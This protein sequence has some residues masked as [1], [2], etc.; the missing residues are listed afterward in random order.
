MSGSPS[1]ST[2]ESFGPRRGG[3]PRGGVPDLGV[4][5]AYSDHMEDHEPI[6][7]AHKSGPKADIAVVVPERVLADTPV[8]ADSRERSY[9]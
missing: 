7:L 3:R 6:D 5:Q 2:A 9:L 1:P 4:T 8:R